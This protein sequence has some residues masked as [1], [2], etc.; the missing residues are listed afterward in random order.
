MADDVVF[1]VVGEARDAI[2]DLNQVV[3]AQ[4]KMIAGMKKSNDESKK[5]AKSGKDVGRGFGEA[6]KAMAGMVASALSIQT[7]TSIFSGM[8][9][10][11][12]QLTD[13]ANQSAES[14]Q[15]LL[16]V[17]SSSKDFKNLQAIGSRISQQYGI[18]RGAANQLVFDVR[19]ARNL[20]DE[21]V[22]FFARTQKVFGDATAVANSVNQVLENFGSGAGNVRQ[23]TNKLLKS[24][25]SVSGMTASQVAER[26]KVIAPSAQAAGYSFDDTLATFSAA[27]NEFG[28]ERAATRLNTFLAKAEQGG[29]A[30]RSFAEGLSN[31]RAMS[32]EDQKSLMANQEFSQA[33]KL[34]TNQLSNAATFRSGITAS[35]QAGPGNDL[36]GGKI[37]QFYDDRYLSSLDRLRRSQQSLNEAGRYKS[38]EEQMTNAYINESRASSLRRNENPVA[39]LARTGIQRSLQF[40]NADEGVLRG[41]DRINPVTTAINNADRG[42]FGAFLGTQGSIRNPGD[43]LETG[44]GQGRSLKEALDRNTESNKALVRESQVTRNVAKRGGL[45]PGE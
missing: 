3:R 24:A 34:L 20:K 25:E 45:Y 44:G 7:V 10:E 22:D 29:F 42:F 38:V 6:K 35:G 8:R 19:S 41:V 13:A 43:I 32:P 36:I 21:D 14:I 30:G 16:Q 40:L 33:V 39:R 31:F 12:E 26:M 4:N 27:A 37:R 28:P 2:K 17:S 18:D 5:L 1:K 15:R 23:I 9:S 11:V